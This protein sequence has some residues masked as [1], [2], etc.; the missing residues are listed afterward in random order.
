MCIQ[1][2]SI[3]GNSSTSRCHPL[4]SNSTLRLRMPQRRRTQEH[5]REQTASG[6]SHRSSSCLNRALISS[7]GSRFMIWISR[8][9]SSRKRSCP[10]RWMELVARDGIPPVPLSCKCMWLTW[11]ELA[12]TRLWCNNVDR[13]SIRAKSYQSTLPY[14]TNAYNHCPPV[15]IHGSADTSALSKIH[16]PA[17]LCL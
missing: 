4:L 13:V 14:P 1:R 5:H 17:P 10:H 11:N 9:L 6:Q 3:G 8:A 16:G 7:V 15:E 12:T 2:T